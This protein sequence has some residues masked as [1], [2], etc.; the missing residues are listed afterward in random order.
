MITFWSK[1]CPIK[2]NLKQTMTFKWLC[3]PPKQWP[4]NDN[5]YY[6][7]SINEIATETVMSTA[8]T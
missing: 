4:S 3:T 5:A 7:N 1:K 6:S 8:C 2:H